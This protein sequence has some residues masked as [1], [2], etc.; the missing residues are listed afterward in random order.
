MGVTRPTHPATP[1]FAIKTEHGPIL[2]TTSSTTKTPPCT[3]RL[4]PSFGLKVLRHCCPASWL[5]RRERDARRRRSKRRHHHQLRGPQ[6]R[7]RRIPGQSHHFAG[8]LGGKHRCRQTTFFILP[9]TRRVLPSCSPLLQW[10]RRFLLLPS[11]P[12]HPPHLPR[13]LRIVLPHLFHQTPVTSR[14][15]TKTVSPFMSRHSVPRSAN[16]SKAR[17]A[18]TSSWIWSTTT[19]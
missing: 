3:Q 1:P 4:H 10:A 15:R 18:T 11:C 2:T 12:P 17:G 5:P 6:L 9:P 8:R 19:A 14:H 13:Q 7:R 16:F